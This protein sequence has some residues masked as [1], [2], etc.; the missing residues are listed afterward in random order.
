MDLLLGISLL[1]LTLITESFG[2]FCKTSA[3]Y[4]SYRYCSNG[5][6]KYTGYNVCCS[7]YYYTYNS[8][9]YRST[10]SSSG[11]ATSIIWIIICSVGFVVTVV[12]VIVVICCCRRRRGAAGAV[13]R[14]TPMQPMVISTNNVQTGYM[15]PGIAYPQGQP[16]VM[17][18]QGQPSEGYPQ[19]A[20]GY[21]Q[22]TTVGYP[23]QA[24]PGYPQQP[25]PQQQQLESKPNH[26]PTHPTA[27]SDNSG[28]SA[29]PSYES[30]S[31]SRGQHNT[32][33]VD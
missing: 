18:S 21:S 7:S 20:P 12:I 33:Y 26:Y 10:Y 1:L 24:D 19:P 25:Q 27:L 15:Q 30:L 8:Y 2:T 17:Y 11:L 6:C 22:Q 28:L 31:P 32:G 4:N 14:S 23:Q 16:G 9:T 13:V 5:C 29:P 3:L